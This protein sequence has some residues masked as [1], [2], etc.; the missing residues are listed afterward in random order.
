[1]HQ[2]DHVAH[3]RSVLDA[4]HEVDGALLPERQ[5]QLHQLLVD[6]HALAGHGADIPAVTCAH[7]H[8]AQL[9][10]RVAR[11]A[12]AQQ[13]GGT[14]L[15]AALAA[16]RIDAETGLAQRPAEP[17]QAHQP[18]AQ[19]AH[20]GACADHR[21]RQRAEQQPVVPGLGRFLYEPG[22]HH[23]RG[24]QHRQPQ[25]QDAQAHQPPHEPADAHVA[26]KEPQLRPVGHAGVARIEQQAVRRQHARQ[27]GGQA[28]RAQWRCDPE[29]EH[30]G[31]ERKVPVHKS[32]CRCRRRW[33]STTV[34][35]CR[36]PKGGACLDFNP[37][38]FDHHD[39]L[40]G[41]LTRGRKST[42]C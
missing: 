17:A 29:D 16:F 41:P 27:H 22:N 40:A 32:A 37:V 14:D 24:R 31:G 5:C 3:A 18:A 8:M 7:D 36:I 4:A 42:A 35:A 26:W 6:Q 12:A 38:E 10:E 21:H 23:R 20:E 9:A 25:E 30:F 19:P 15:D 1:M 11:D 39:D 13:R 2:R 28:E 33:C 34:R